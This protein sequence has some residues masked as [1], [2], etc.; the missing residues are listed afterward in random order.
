M[1]FDLSAEIK[2]VRPV[3]DHSP[4][5]GE[6]RL[7]AGVFI[8]PQ[9]RI[10]DQVADA[11]C[12]GVG[13]VTRVEMQRIAFNSDDQISGRPVGRRRETATRY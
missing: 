5:F 3:I 7:Q 2:D 9:E 11:N 12:I 1:E 6:L 8:G 10:I 4:A 13:G